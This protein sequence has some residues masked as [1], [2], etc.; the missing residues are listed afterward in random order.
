MIIGPKHWNDDEREKTPQ[1]INKNQ[2]AKLQNATKKEKCIDDVENATNLCE[3]SER[4]FEG[5]HRCH[6]EKWIHSYIIIR[7]WFCF[8]RL[9]FISLD[10]LFRSAGEEGAD[11]WPQQNH[12]QLLVPHDQGLVQHWILYWCSLHGPMQ[13]MIFANDDNIRSNGSEKLWTGWVS[14]ARNL[15]SDSS[16]LF[17]FF[18]PF[19]AWQIFLKRPWMSF[20]HFQN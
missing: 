6:L 13:I 12:I 19:S 20:R 1:N 18:L 14:F 7:S 2:K 17:L 4:F 5:R 16:Y 15:I 8:A 9:N 10:Y 11:L 3:A